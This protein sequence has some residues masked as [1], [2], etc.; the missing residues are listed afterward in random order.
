MWVCSLS[1]TYSWWNVEFSLGTDR[2]EPNFCRGRKTEKLKLLSRKAATW[3]RPK[4]FV[5]GVDTGPVV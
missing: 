1:H 5:K 2:F 3:K 4:E